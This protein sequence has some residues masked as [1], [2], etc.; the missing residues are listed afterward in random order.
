VRNISELAENIRSGSSAAHS[1]IIEGGNDE[2]RERLV[3]GL[4]EELGCHA[5][6]VVRMEM[7]GRNSYKTS[8]ANA[9]IERLDMDAYGGFLV[10]IIDDGDSLSE[11]VQNKLLKTLEEPS[12]TG[13]IFIGSANRD[14]LLD[15]V[16][17]RCSVIRLSDYME[18]ADEEDSGSEALREAAQL[19]AAAAGT[20]PFY[21]TRNAIEKC[22]KTDRD[23]L[24]IID[25]LEDILREKMTGGESPLVCAENIEKAERTRADIER[26]MDKNRA[27]KRLRLEL[28]GR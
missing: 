16:R 3:Q 11:V 21:E 4:I 12:G 24:A 10:G 18:D 25:M 28:S 13:L 27:L 15:T 1:Y 2:A 14:Y 20:T 7:S 19:L 22:V 9:F 5:L 26:G 17:S 8:D 6:D 23:A